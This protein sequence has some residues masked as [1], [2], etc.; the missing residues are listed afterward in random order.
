MPVGLGWF[1]WRPAALLVV[2][3]DGAATGIT[4][5]A[6]SAWDVSLAVGGAGGCGATSTIVVVGG[7]AA[8]VTAGEGSAVSA[9]P[10]VALASVFLSA[11]TAPNVPRQ[12]TAPNAATASKR[13]RVW[14]DRASAGV[15]ETIPA[16]VIAP[17]ASV[18]P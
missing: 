10:V 9:I 11:V 13:L 16:S 7:G 12:R 8:L 15:P 14:L 4:A 2:R 5:G 1:T 6:G 18:A 3:A 17:A